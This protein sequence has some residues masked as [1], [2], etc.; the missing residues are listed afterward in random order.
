MCVR[1]RARACACVHARVRVFACP[2]WLTMKA[3][4]SQCCISSDSDTGSVLIVIIITAV[5]YSHYS[6][7]YILILFG[8]LK[9]VSN[10]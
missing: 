6:S 8:L 7:P 1:A 2:C 10:L 5:E 9:S 3:V 4:L